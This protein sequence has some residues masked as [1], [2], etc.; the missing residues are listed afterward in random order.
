MTNG[1][2]EGRIRVPRCCLRDK[3]L[4]RRREPNASPVW[5]LLSRNE[6]MRQL[7]FANIMDLPV[8]FDEPDHEIIRFCSMYAKEIGIKY[9]VSLTVN[10]DDNE[11]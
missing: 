9:N 6:L 11:F 3:V 4:R 7:D 10:R 5:E 1:F 2:N 8:P